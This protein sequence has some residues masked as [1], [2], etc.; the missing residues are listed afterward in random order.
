MMR[1]R[2]NKQHRL[3][4]CRAKQTGLSQVVVGRNRNMITRR[5]TEMRKRAKKRMGSERSQRKRRIHRMTTTL[6][7]PD[8]YII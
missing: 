7:F 6:S 8:D 4:A 2:K 1:T 3:P 5:N